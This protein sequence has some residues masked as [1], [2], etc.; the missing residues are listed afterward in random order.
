MDKRCACW[1]LRR[2]AASPRDDAAAHRQ[3][4]DQIENVVVIYAENRSFDNLYGT[5][6]G[7]N[8]LAERHA[9]SMHAARPRRHAAARSCRR[10]GTG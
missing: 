8:G 3:K 4:L 7:A 10:S 6:P 5:F 1:P 2:G 9:G